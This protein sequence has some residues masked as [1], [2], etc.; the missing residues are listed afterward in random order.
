MLIQD[1]R[2]LG[3]L[4]YGWAA[5]N[6]DLLSVQRMKNLQADYPEPSGD[7]LAGRLSLPHA[8]LNRALDNL[9][10]TGSRTARGHHYSA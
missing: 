4:L 5:R 8:S 2:R 9:H 3:D 10:A 6:A 7:L 1:E